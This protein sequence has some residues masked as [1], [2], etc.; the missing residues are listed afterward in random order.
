[1]KHPGTQGTSGIKVFDYMLGATG[2]NADAAKFYKIET[3][4]VTY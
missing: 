1:M 3:E 4:T 2:V